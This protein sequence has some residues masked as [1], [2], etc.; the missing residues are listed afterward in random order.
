[1][2]KSNL[3]RSVVFFDGGDAGWKKDENGALV[4]G[5]DGN[6]IYVQTDGAEKAV[7][8]SAIA[9]LN[10]EARINRE[11]AERAEA[12][13]KPFEGLDPEKARAA[14]VAVENIDQDKLVASEQLEKLRGEIT[15]S[16]QD[17]LKERDATIES[18]R[19]AIVDM[20]LG[21]AFS[22]SKFIADKLAIPVDLAR[23]HFGKHFT[24]D[25]DGKITAK[26]STGAELYDP[27][28][29]GIAATFEQA[30]EQIIDAYPQRDTILKGD[31]H[32]GGGGKGAS[33][34]AGAGGKRA[35]NRS[36]FDKMTPVKQAEVAGQI[37]E[38]KAVLTD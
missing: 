26:S 38:G 35:F 20:R 30:I 25:D 37:K 22:G 6:P 23:S 3:L 10:N 13:Y 19:G 29:P 16:F 15:A 14:L 8:F 9:R 36:D 32:S 12:A 27:N 11:R 17:Q 18:Q 4:V 2:N 31:G 1:M 7:D 34:D 24:V 28:N 33:D 21:A 5:A